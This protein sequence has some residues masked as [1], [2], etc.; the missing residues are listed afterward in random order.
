MKK[1]WIV[2]MTMAVFLL[3]ACGE[4][5]GSELAEEG[6]LPKQQVPGYLSLYNGLCSV[7]HSEKML[8]TEKSSQKACI[9]KMNTIDSVAQKHFSGEA[10]KAFVYAQGY[11]YWPIQHKA[12]FGFDQADFD[13]FVEEAFNRTMDCAEHLRLKPPENL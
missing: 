1:L 8:M 3:S 9:C 13:M 4:K 10:Y 6:L 7:S 2:V 11:R 12:P 5:S